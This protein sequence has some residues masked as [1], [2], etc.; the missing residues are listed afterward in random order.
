MNFAA[1][2]ITDMCTNS[3]VQSNK[4]MNDLCGDIPRMLFP[5]QKVS[6]AESRSIWWYHHEHVKS[7]IWYWWVKDKKRTQQWHN[8]S[9][10]GL[11][12]KLVEEE[13]IYTKG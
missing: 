3:I 12:D 2:E 6:N 7:G 9:H 8:V 4:N 10:K 1:S 13:M 5:S 11:N